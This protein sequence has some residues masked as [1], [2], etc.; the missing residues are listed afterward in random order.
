MT[1]MTTTIAAVITTHNREHLLPRA[2]ASV[3][4]QTRPPDEFFI[5]DDGSTDATA[6]YLK[7]LPAAARV[8]TQPQRGVSAARN[9][10]IAAARSEWLA[11]LDDDDAWLPD[12]LRIQA[13]LIAQN[14]GAY[15]CHGEEIWMRRGKRVNPAA[16][17]QKRGGRIYPDCLPRCVISPST[18]IIH[19]DIFRRL[20]PFDPALPACEDYDLWLRVCARHPVLYTDEALTIKHGGHADQ[21]SQKYF[22]LDRFRIRAM[23]KILAADALGPRERRLT[24]AMLMEKIRIYMNGAA[25]RGRATEAAAYAEKLRRLSCAP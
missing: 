20:G 14:P 23:E 18:A 11:F 25:K 4:A 15:L 8:I 1:T 7:T 2:V 21:L 10:A 12:K 13:E 6:A 5:I 3:L 24:V 22:G 16:K 9:A 17:H 19:R